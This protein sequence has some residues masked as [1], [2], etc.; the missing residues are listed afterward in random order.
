M[1][2]SIIVPSKRPDELIRFEESIRKNSVFNDNI[3]LVI[4]VD[5]EQ[6][7]VEFHHNKTVIHYPPKKP[8]YVSE[9]MHQCYKHSTGD[10][11]MFGNDDI[12]CETPEWDKM[13]FMAIEQYA[14]DG[15]ALFWPDD[16]MFGMQL[17]CFPIISKK[18]LDMIGFF[19]QPYQR[20]KV[21]DTIFHVIPNQRKFYLSNIKFRHHNDEGED[22][23]VLE[24]GKVYP[25]DR[26]AGEHDN[27][28][29][30]SET[31]RRQQMRRVIQTELGINIPRVVI[32]VITQE[33]ARRADFYDCVDAINNPSNVEVF[34]SRIHAQSPAKARNVIIE[35]AILKDCTHILF[36]DDDV[37]PD[38]D[39]LTKL[40]SHDKDIVTGLYLSRAYPHKPFIFDSW[41]NGGARWRPLR[42]E[43]N[44]LIEVVAGGLGCILIK[45]NVFL[46]MEKPWIRLGELESDNWCDDIGFFKRAGEAGFKM[47]CDINC[48]AGHVSSMIIRPKKHNGQWYTSYQSTT[49][50]G[51]PL[52]AQLLPKE[53]LINA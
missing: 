1:R 15:I 48:K 42:P 26:E 50:E 45:I 8:V 9:L 20:Y 51:E 46:A 53:E 3:E 18:F 41:F 34:K 47:Y 49:G 4:L 12:V 17:A 27:A 38:P 32:G 35:E 25:I 16:C 24:N 21:D 6:E 37:Y 29:W 10:W 19:P 40:L 30:T 36:L 43:D 13:L 44:G 23:F 11:I 7:Y 5:D 22:G 14:Q 39:I 52:V 28:V 2:L 33:M 31:V